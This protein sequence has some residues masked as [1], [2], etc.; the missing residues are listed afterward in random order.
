[1]IC[2]STVTTTVFCIL[3]LVTLPIF[4]CLLLIRLYSELLSLRGSNLELRFLCLA[5]KFHFLSQRFRASN[6][7]AQ[8]A[9]FHP[10]FGLTV[11]QLELEAKKLI[12]EFAHLRV[13]LLRRPLPHLFC[14][15]AFDAPSTRRLLAG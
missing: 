3:L 7:L 10:R 12:G 9:N 8:G 11:Q 15:H 14:L 1:M 6:I 5:L 4:S 2:R 13:K